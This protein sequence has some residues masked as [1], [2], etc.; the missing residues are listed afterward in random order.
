MWTRCG[1]TLVLGLVLFG[2]LAGCATVSGRDQ[3]YITLPNA[4]NPE[5]LV[6]P[7][8]LIA[9]PTHLLANAFQYAIV[10]PFYFGMNAMPNAVGLSLQE[11]QYI[12]QRQEAWQRSSEAQGAQPAK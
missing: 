1:R 5:Y 10:E 9:L 2:L 11:Q 8:R 3:D 4:E 6:H 7:F 12:T